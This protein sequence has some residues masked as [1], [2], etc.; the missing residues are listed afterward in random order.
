MT[1]SKAG[2]A[3]FALVAVVVLGA[4]AGRVAEGQWVPDGQWTQTFAYCSQAWVCVPSQSIIHA[5]D[6]QVITTP[7]QSTIGSCNVG[8]G[9]VSSC[10]HCSAAPP[11]MACQVTLVAR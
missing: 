9:D 10:N 5:P 7:R 6:M 2:R 4:Q 1:W 8:G 3:T 11:D